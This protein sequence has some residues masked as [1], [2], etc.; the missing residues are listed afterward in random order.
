M[1]N[2]ERHRRTVLIAMLLVAVLIAS[3]LIFQYISKP[4]STPAPSPTPSISPIPTTFS[5][6]PTG[7]S[8][9]SPTISPTPTPTPVPTPFLYPGEITQYQNQNLT[10]IRDLIGNF[11]ASSIIGAQDINQ[12]TYRLNITGLV[13]QN[14]EYTYGYV[15]NN[16]QAHQEVVELYCVEGWNVNILWEGISVNDL[17]QAAGVSPQANTLIFYASD[18]YS[19]SLPLS[20]VV[21]NNLIIAYKMNNVTL[22]AETGWPFILVAENQTGYK[23]IKWLTQID[24]S[25]DSSYLGYWESRGYPNNATL[26]N[27]SHSTPP[28]SN[29][30]VSDAVAVSGAGTV[31]AAV[32]YFKLVKTSTKQSKFWRRRSKVKEILLRT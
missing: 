16:F 13:N 3:L 32:I 28:N 29:A 7:T 17:L 22:T 8:S 15:V 14:L 24:V 4:S 20:Y 6:S 23:W 27:P 31:A 26:D 1:Q 5:P 19:T 2:P 30:T 18:G 21:Q 11:L 12:T 9:P 10:A 25:N